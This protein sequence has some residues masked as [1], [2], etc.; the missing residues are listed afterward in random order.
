[1]RKLSLVVAAKEPEYV[2]RLAEYIR[3]APAASEWQMTACTQPQAL[4]Q[5]IKGGYPVDL[6]LLQPEFETHI[7]DVVHY[8]L[9][10]VH[11]VPFITDSDQLQIVQFQSL[12]KLIRQLNAQLGRIR[13]IS[14]WHIPSDST[15][16]LSLFSSMGGMGKTTLALNIAR[17][18]SEAG[19]N[20]FYFNVEPYNASD[21]YLREHGDNSEH[22]Y[23]MLLYVL[24]SN[25]GQA[26]Q[27]LHASTR[28][29][30]ELGIDYFA[31]AANPDERHSLS[32]E[33]VAL[34]IQTIVDS[35][36]YDLIVADM[37]GTLDE[38][39][40][41][42][43]RI[44]HLPLWLTGGDATSQRK[45][46]IMLQYGAHK[47]GEAFI[48]AKRK[49]RTI[50]VYASMARTAAGL[51]QEHH[52]SDH[53]KFSIPYMAD[54]REAKDPVQLMASPVYRGLVQRIMRQWIWPEGGD[55]YDRGCG[56]GAAQAYSGTH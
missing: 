34:T 17:E 14:A 13:G 28:R 43:L 31:P 6:L 3:E 55:A 24:Q 52:G 12:P 25:P 5:Y 7:S 49:I 45:M 29:N 8:A 11:L 37:G 32:G 10:V 40:F 4:R 33:L 18:A 9:P 54:W 19:K 44:S 21:L 20:V 16:V 30:T 50:Q 47:W 46:D 42:L 27:Q 48:E 22:D 51:P 23:S 1:M 36:R 41:N 53:A 15:I 26:L 39:G 35:G 56:V 2:R 38:V